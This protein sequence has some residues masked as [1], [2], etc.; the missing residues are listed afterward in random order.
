MIGLVGQLLMLRAIY[1]RKSKRMT[2]TMRLINI[3]SFFALSYLI[4]LTPIGK[5][6]K[7][8]FCSSTFVVTCHFKANRCCETFPECCETFPVCCEKFPVC[9]DSFPVCC[10]TFL[11]CCN[12]FPKNPFAVK[13]ESTYLKLSVGTIPFFGWG[14]EQVHVLVGTCYKYYTDGFFNVALKVHIRYDWVKFFFWNFGPSQW[15]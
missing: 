6:I 4:L 3:N 10:E 13:W 12:T 1:L 14:R 15:N 8:S 11:V 9:C 5:D 7:R 2:W